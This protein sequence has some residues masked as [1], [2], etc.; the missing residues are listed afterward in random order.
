MTDNKGMEERELMRRWVETWKQAGPELEA[1]RQ[2][3]IQ[4]ADNDQVLRILESSMNFAL[5]SPARPSSG[6][7]EMQ[8]LFAKL[9]LPNERP[10]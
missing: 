2:R 4:E 3:E 6:L 8:R 1:I 10:S 5:H 9:G 7:V